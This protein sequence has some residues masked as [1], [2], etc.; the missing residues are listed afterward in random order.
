MLTISELQNRWLSDAGQEILSEVKEL[1]LNNS[2]RQKFYTLLSSLEGSEEINGYLDFRGIPITAG[3]IELNLEISD[4][5][6]ANKTNDFF[7]VS[8]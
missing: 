5:S 2:D 3:L 1:I 7:S 8:I 6:F 4:F